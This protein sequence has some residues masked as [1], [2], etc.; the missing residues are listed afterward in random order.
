MAKTDKKTKKTSDK[1][2]KEQVYSGKVFIQASFNNTIMT[3]TDMEG[4]VVAWASAGHANFKGSRKSTPYAA[5]IVA[6]D[7][8][9]KMQMK[10][11]KE[12]DIFVKGP[13]I[14][15]ESAIRVIGNSGF[16]IHSIQDV[17]P[18]PHNGCRPQ[19]K[20]RV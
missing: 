15:R 7:I 6:K 19:K 20:R 11:M 18:L 4:N 10:G 13:G 12:C 5:Q 16:V 2:S 9:K 1:K 14:G 8:A 17:T 3:A